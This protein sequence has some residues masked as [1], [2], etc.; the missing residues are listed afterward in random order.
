MTMFIPLTHEVEVEVG[1]ILNDPFKSVPGH[2]KGWSVFHPSKVH[3]ELERVFE[4]T[5]VQKD[6]CQEQI[7]WATAELPLSNP[8]P[9]FQTIVNSWNALASYHA[10]L[11][12]SL[13]TDSQ[14]G[15]TFVRVL[16]RIEHIAPATWPTKISDE[17][18]A[19]LIWECTDQGDFKL[20]LNFRKALLD[21]K[22]LEIIKTD[23]FLLLAGLPPLERLGFTS[24]VNYLKK[25]KNESKS[26]AFWAESFA[27][28]VPS[29]SSSAL[30]FSASPKSNRRRSLTVQLDASRWQ[31][32]E[33]PI[34]Q[35]TQTYSSRRALFELTWALVVS[36][37]TDTQDVIFGT[38]GRDN[39]FLGVDSTVGCLDHTYLVRVNVSQDSIVGHL[40]GVIDEYHTV[41]EGHA[42]VGLNEILRQLSSRKTVESVLNYTQG[43]SFQCLAPGL[44]KFPI[45][46]TVCDSDHPSMTLTYLE[47]I[48]HRDAEII[49]DQ[50]VTG[51]HDVFNNIDS[52][53][54]TLGD[55]NLVS[56]RER[57]SLLSGA[58][59]PPQIHPPTLSSLIEKSLSLYPSRIAVTFEDKGSITYKELNGL[60]NGLARA[61]Q[62]PRGGVVPLL[63]ERSVN[64]VVTILALLKSGV[65]Y[66]ILNPDIPAER[67]AQVIKECS[68]IV[69]LADRKYSHMIP[70]ASSI[71][72]LL[73]DSATLFTQD[74]DWNLGNKP[75]PDDVSYIIYTSGSTGKPKGTLITNRAAANGI[76]QHQTLED[77][78]KILLFYSPTASAA[79]R[80][81]ISTLVHG[82]TILLASKE[83][84][85]ANLAG[86]INKYHADFMEITPTALSL[87][88][89]SDIPNI[90]Q[91]TVAG[92]NIPQALVD[93]WAANKDLTVR[94]RYGS[95]ECTQ[96]SLGRRL[97]PGDNPR[98]LGASADTTITYILRVGSNELVPTGVAGELCL[99]GPQLA[100]GYLHEPE[101]TRRVFVPN[102]F[103][104]GKLYRTG[105]RARKFADGSIEIISRIDWQVKINGNKVEPADVD[106]AIV[107][108]KSVA[109]CATFADKVGGYLS[110]I[111]AVVPADEQQPWSKL[112]P[113]L[114]K[115]ALD[116]LPSYMVP[117]FWMPLPELPRS[118][119]GKVDLKKLRSQSSE[120]GVEGFAALAMSKDDQEEAIT[121]DL[122][123][124]IATVWASVIGIQTHIIKRHH[125]F[126]A[127]GGNSLQAIKTI[128]NLRREGV[129][130][131]FS[132]LLT[133]KSLQHVAEIARNRD[134][135][136]AVQTEP[137]SLI[138]NVEFLDRLKGQMEA[139][140]AYPATPLQ[141]GLLPT[142]NE[143]G[144]PYI[145]R[146]TWDVH[147]LDFIKLKASFERIFHSND[148]LR[149]G[150]V[151][152]DRS[153]IQVVRSDLSLPWSEA[154]SSLEEYIQAD[155]KVDLPLEGPLFRI[156]LVD[157]KWLVVTMHHSLCD[158]WSHGFL[159]A[160][161]AA[162]YLDQPVP[163]RP[164]FVEFVRHVVQQDSPT[165]RNFWLSYL[166][167]AS[168]SRLNFTPVEQTAR[169]SK[170]VSLNLHARVQPL[171]VTTGAVVYTAWAIV[172]S[173]HQN[174]QDVTFATTLSG[175]ELPIL[176]VENID[177]PTVTTVP[178]RFKIGSQQSLINLVRDVCMSGFV[179]VTQHAQIGMQGA[180]RAA[181]LPS[182][183]F[184]TLVN[185]LAKEDE[186][187][188]ARKVFKPYGSRPIWD[189]PYTMLEIVPNESDTTIRMS[190]NIESLRLQFLCDSFIKVVG[191]ILETPEQHALSIDV[192][193][194]AER[195]YLNNTLSNRDTLRTPSARLL[196]SE[197]E[198]RT[199]MNPT[200][201]AIE[202]D[203]IEQV[204]YASLNKRSNH[205]ANLLIR[206]GLQPGDRIA[207]MLD[208]SV[209]AVV[210]II[211]SL[212]AGLTYV[213]L[214]PENPVERNAF[215]C[216]ET[217]SR[218]LIL[219]KNDESFSSQA[220]DL[221]TMVVEDIPTLE[222]EETP[223]VAVNGDN[224]AYIIY[225]SGSTGQPKGIKVP[226]RAAAAAIESGSRVEGRFDGEWRA[227]QMANYVFDVSVLDIFNTLSTGG[228]LCMAPME[229]LL[230]DM[231]GCMN[232][233]R[234]RQAVLT[235]TVASLVQPSDV[236]HLDTLILAG[237]Q[238]PKT[239]VDTWRP[240]CRVLNSYGPT[241]TSMIVFSKEIQL[242]GGPAANIG[243]PYPTV[244]AFVVDPDGDTLR[245]Y[246][247]V[248]ELCIAG[249]QLA[250]G[251]LDRDDLTAA[252]FVQSETLGLRIYR[253]GDLARWLP[254]GDLECL[255]RK[256][257][258]IKIHGFRVELGEVESAIRQSGL[259]TDAVV[260]LANV[261]EKPQLVAVCIFKPSSESAKDA[262]L[263]TSEPSIPSIQPAEKHRSNFL[264]L[265]TRLNSLAHYMIPKVVIP[266]ND[267]P[268]LPSHKADR[269]ALIKMIESLDVL[270]LSAY[271]LETA[272][273]DI[274][275]VPAE[276]PLEKAL[277]VMW[278]EVLN[279]STTKI[280]REANFLSLGGDSIAAISLA[281]MARQA[282]YSLG[283]ATILKVPKLK[284]LAMKITIVEK[285]E[286][287][288]KP[289]FEVSQKVRDSIA[290]TGLVWEEDVDYVY[291]CPPGQVEFLN[292]GGREDQ[293]WVLHTVRR[294]PSGVDWERWV[295]STTE[296]TKVEDI[297]RTS[298]MKLSE[299][300]WIGMVLRSP[301]L[302]L[303]CVR[304]QNEQEAASVIEATWNER[305]VFGKPFIRYTIITYPDNSWDLVT[306]L[307]HAVYDGT[308]LRIFD[309][310][311]GSIL[312]KQ[313]IPRHTTFKDFAFYIFES[314][315]SRSLDYWTK[316]LDG[317]DA[318]VSLHQASWAKAPSPCTDSII[319]R[320]LSTAG[321]DQAA[322]SLGVT[323]SILFQ[324]SFQLWL[325]GATASSDVGFDY[326]LTGRNVD[327]PEPQTI[328][329]TVA[330]FLPVRATV[331]PEEHLAS[332][333]GR[334]QDDF[335][336]MTDHGDVGLDQIFQASGLNRQEV[337]NRAL[338]I[339][340]PFEPAPKDDPNADF[341]WL[342]MA[343]CKVRMPTPYV[344]A[345]EVHK[346]AGKTHSLKISYDATVMGVKAAEKAADEIVDIIHRMINLKG[347]MLD[348]R[349]KD[350]QMEA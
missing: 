219:H 18:L 275:I 208:K 198:K 287:P 232:R 211:G 37:H 237:E 23:F 121:D 123:L 119:N 26:K 187:E 9:S 104:E 272:G 222:D 210:C 50:V 28:T 21:A 112:L 245:P 199:S 172:L 206:R 233:M 5:Q 71:E 277:E 289:I 319:R 85:A 178:Q 334:T 236:P 271:V 68:P 183:H 89:P 144:D 171:G 161:V 342:V 180:L 57:S 322:N 78:T 127:L 302:D 266:M 137:F 314:D 2:P 197:F 160:D 159:Y 38:V 200:H 155:T 303:T 167:G 4:A 335:W 258:Q 51:L 158:F 195:T 344:L 84:L 148:I 19:H 292:Q 99:S 134:Y 323:P 8:L 91:I 263:Q 280:G 312:R 61:L 166:Q 152:H 207:L 244:M 49:M 100:S 31:N 106:H 279:I 234:V 83:S 216:R 93:T 194:D 286:L 313:P 182:D 157:A 55:V 252:A 337:G 278:A 66:T 336:A 45:V 203:G 346:A 32:P 80:T 282:G 224:H 63:M 242:D 140:D 96:M 116:S 169:I 170:N 54:R 143:E 181:N 209:E 59:V 204:S 190:G 333:L 339:Y 118:V 235:P 114:R 328:N 58:F 46:L 238:V 214:S 256:D 250:D 273:Q 22:S 90:K 217:L 56:E 332:F 189:T 44:E 40:A 247:A 98:L 307:D 309:D 141:A 153:F 92:E 301:Q 164:R 261:H 145:Y 283:V 52:A 253:T 7:Q 146:R 64:L 225:T 154:N 290:A 264:A 165:A 34:L 340:Q 192:M 113:I 231:A 296:L 128:S 241:E 95:S 347:D 331:D 350:V 12:S 147:G 174:S 315:K 168:R 97:R 16:R 72:D 326:L 317:W 348:K 48:P 255:G 65:A 163:T 269:K 288:T 248:G 73:T 325:A 223:V 262:T 124:K 27:R 343:K 239:V 179:G 126:L 228:T 15:H 330:N 267:L 316:R 87:L 149:T 79:Q 294:M 10:C 185:L 218:L 14:T 251:Y 260:M 110:L 33:D 176:D 188:T 131:G 221:E 341:R 276:T 298:W 101:L 300:E 77:T 310:H 3:P 318:A 177:G 35:G 47:S 230:S 175:R 138:K 293:L 308:L 212:K 117:S 162:A 81:F 311:Y 13:S 297:L 105:D 120:L 11:R 133:D 304:C 156:G 76:M 299:T 74:N 306:K 254:G 53:H 75:E 268:I 229:K 1:Q 215:I 184:D 69:I 29:S 62:L 129:V 270:E 142:L 320:P 60:A 191:A 130:V 246:G 150:F 295:E 193:G 86:V 274:E 327:L 281:S 186:G 220:P 136:A 201:T 70:S 249:P 243:R 6:I 115:H 324:G 139:A 88:R 108:H 17:R 24:Y 173:A 257:S 135:D 284:E 111:T 349:I 226:H 259:V 25:T 321:V 94:N 227:L 240:V 265:Q 43:S 41:A 213:P 67:N 202:W 103:G 39:G 285:S 291:P 125:S 151:L 338:F 345:V 36:E 132:T 305:F 30:L 102:P 205:L 20:H 329:G 42:F 196:H 107:Q 109:T 122:E 82:G